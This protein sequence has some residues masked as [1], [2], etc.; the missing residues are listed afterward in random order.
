MQQDCVPYDTKQAEALES[1]PAEDAMSAMLPET[2]EDGLN[3]NDVDDNRGDGQGVRH[4]G[5]RGLEGSAGCFKRNFFIS[6]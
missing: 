6:T 3:E 4:S 5:Q 1:E 2:V